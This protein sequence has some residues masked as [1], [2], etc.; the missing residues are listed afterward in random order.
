MFS[1]EEIRTE[2]SQIRLPLVVLETTQ[3]QPNSQ[4]SAAESLRNLSPYEVNLSGT[5]VGSA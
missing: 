1:A 3:L 4:V 5:C 2:E